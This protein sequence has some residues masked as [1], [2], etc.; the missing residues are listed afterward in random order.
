MNGGTE[1]WYWTAPGKLVFDAISGVGEVPIWGY[2][3]S[4]NEYILHGLE[5]PKKS[6]V[7]NPYSYD[8][9]LQYSDGQPGQSTVYSDRMSDWDYKKYR[10]LIDKHFDNPGDYFDQ[11]KHDQIESF[12]RDYLDKPEIILCAVIEYCNL[13]SGYPVWRFDYV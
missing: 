11:R 12:L 9:I 5:I 10:D 3:Y 13:V 8:P 4:Q 1:K 2:M 7:L 6:K